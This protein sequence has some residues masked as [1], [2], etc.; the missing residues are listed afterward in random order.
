MKEHVLAI[1]GLGVAAIPI[2]EKAK[3]MKLKTVGFGEADSMYKN[4]VDVF[5]KKSIFDV[6]GMYEACIANNVTGVIA[7]SEITTEP[8]ALLADK[9]QLPGNSVKEGFFARNKYLMRQRV[10]NLNNV[11]QPKYHLY[12][13]G[14]KV[15][16]PVVVKAVDS[17]GKQGISLAKNEAELIEAIKEAR[18]YSSNST[19][20]IEEYIAGGKEYS[21]E[22]L[23]CNGKCTVVQVTD[24]DSSGPPHFAETGHHQPAN[25]SG[26]MREKI[27]SAAGSILGVL[28]INCGMAHLEIKIR[29]GEIYFIEV[30]ARG[31]G[32]H[33]ADTLTILSTDCD[34]YKAAIECSLGTYVPKAIH[35]IA[36]SG[37]YFHIRQNEALDGVFKLAKNADWVYENTV[38]TDDYPD[39]VFFL[40]RMKAGYVIYKS[41]H[42]ICMS[43]ILSKKNLEAECINEYPNA[44]ELIWKHNKEI[45]RELSDEDLEVGI[46]KF[47]NKGNVISILD[48]N[49]IVAFL[50]L[51]CNNYETLG[52]YICNVYVLD[53][54]RGCNLSKKL[55]DKAIAIC[56]EKNFKKI[57]LHV[58]RD[59]D[60]AISLYEKYGFSFTG[61][62]NQQNKDSLEMELKI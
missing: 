46:N 56:K 25:I 33:I 50:M 32:S 62:V 16:F 31:G 1:V 8:T 26:Q 42:K 53:K 59:N 40:D 6:D 57:N 35:N 55:M 24:K 29:N 60:V 36:Y 45:G 43:D 9:L 51:Y 21:V 20:L 49:H 54:Y 52:A 19:A 2:I 10:R 12:E 38:A 28:G 37:L 3:E 15:E 48:D 7:S 27:E 5:V 44:F 39:A 17:C 58:D 13:D 34:Y 18:K 22:C 4:D 47:L 14:E 30:G 11:R 41:D 61:E 23:A